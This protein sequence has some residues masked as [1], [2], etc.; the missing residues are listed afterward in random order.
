MLRDANPALWD[1]MVRLYNACPKDSMTEL[2]E[3]VLAVRTIAPDAPAQPTAAPPASDAKGPASGTA[4]GP[5]RGRAG[6]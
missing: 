5:A 4:P 6:R 3:A 1:R 2:C